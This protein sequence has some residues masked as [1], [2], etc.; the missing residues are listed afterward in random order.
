MCNYIQIQYHCG[1]FRFPV[2]RWCHVY[3]R[4]HK[5]CQPNVTCAEW[6]GD[7]VCPDC[8]PVPLSA[9]ESMIRRPRQSPYV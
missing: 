3:E 8:R 5:K 7:E 2:Q 1:H 6:R 9:W 4:T